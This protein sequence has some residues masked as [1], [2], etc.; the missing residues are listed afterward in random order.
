MGKAFESLN[1]LSA[2]VDDL[3]AQ[4]PKPT[5]S[6][7]KVDMS[8]LKE[9]E[10]TLTPDEVKLYSDMYKEIE[11]DE[12][13]A[14]YGD[15]LGEMGGD[16]TAT[17]TAT[18]TSTA[19]STTSPAVINDADGIGALIQDDDDQLTAVDLSMYEE[20][21]TDEGKAVYGDIL[22]EMG[23]ASAPASNTSPPVINDADGIGA[24]IQ[25]D[26]EQ[27]IAVELSQDTDEFMRR[28][29]EE[30]LQ[31]A[32]TQTS[33]PTIDDSILMDAELMEEI[34]AV[35]DRANEKLLTSISGM[36]EEQAAISKASADKRTKGL[37]EEEIRLRQAG[38]SVT[39]LVD[40]VKM[41][42]VG[43]EKAVA[44]LK[45]AQ[46]SLL[47]SPLM[48]AADLK[49]AGLVRQSALVGAVLFSF[50]SV[51]ELLLVSQGADVDAHG[52]AAAV[53]G[54]IALACGAY[55]MFF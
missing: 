21:D 28:A 16:A 7:I 29:L 20:L 9:N 27:L 55:L 4:P 10:S 8:V 53:Q 44:E 32:K 39:R 33:S 52:F 43:V 6:T 36:K 14:L 38:N 31:E 17:A 2:F 22:D 40:K 47:E 41:E 5:E 49:K 46:E 19:T 26:D 54:L 15:I 12:G 18:A 50:R 35:F 34:N 42:T 24:L 48:K 30:A 37:E 11:A 25:D 23:G 3:A 51:V 1:D 45:E 13:E